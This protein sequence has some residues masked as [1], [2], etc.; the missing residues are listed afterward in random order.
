MEKTLKDYTIA[1]VIKH[2]LFFKNMSELLDELWDSR[3]NARNSVKGQLKAHPIDGLV[4]RDK[5]Q[6]AEMCVMY[7]EVMDK[8]SNEN[9]TVRHFIRSCGNEV[10]NKTV[11]ML[12]D[13]EAK[14][15]A[16][17]TN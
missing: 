5:W 8:K 15:G 6:A 12:Q 10:F 7:A 14:A 17:R 9:A 16:E 13:E 11:K 4:K 3:T 2:P 1:D